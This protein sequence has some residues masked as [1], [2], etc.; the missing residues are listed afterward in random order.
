MFTFVP[1]QEWHWPQIPDEGKPALSADIKGIVALNE[2]GELEAACCFDSWAFNSCQIHIYIKN[3]FVLKHGFAAE[4][5][6]YAFVTCG[7]GKVI[8]VT[9][10][11]NLKALKFIKNIGLKEIFK[12]KDGYKKG[13]DFVL[14]ELNREDCRW[15]DDTERLNAIGEN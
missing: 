7:K 13:V 8:G 6:K 2:A 10:A 4:V 5:F 12:I 1:L 14:T 15:L 11:D 3:P 9:A